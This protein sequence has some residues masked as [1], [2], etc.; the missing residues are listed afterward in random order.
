[1]LTPTLRRDFDFLWRDISA[2]AAGDS[3]P[4]G[5]ASCSS[6]STAV[7][8]KALEEGEAASTAVGER[9]SASPGS[10]TCKRRQVRR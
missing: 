4:M 10:G 8:A 2:A 3:V 5:P 9:R 7:V 6:S 1:M